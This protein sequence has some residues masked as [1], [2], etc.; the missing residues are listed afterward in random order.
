MSKILEQAIAEARKLPPDEQDA[1]GAIILAEIADEARWAKTFAETQHVLE[2][3]AEE[4]LED[5]KAG[6]T[7]PLDFSNRK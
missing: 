3:L 2:K 4:A 7:T 1:V 6:R 5:L